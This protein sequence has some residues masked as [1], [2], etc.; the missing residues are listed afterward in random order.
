M[1]VLTSARE[2]EAVFVHLLGCFSV[3]RVL[4]KNTHQHLALQTV[5][6]G[7]EEWSASFLSQLGMRPA[8]LQ[9]KG[10]RQGTAQKGS[11]GGEAIT[12]PTVVP[13]A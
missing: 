9:A 5:C 8:L 1:D 6:L 7:V 12:L 4:L 11:R 3:L 2:H 13:F 10:D